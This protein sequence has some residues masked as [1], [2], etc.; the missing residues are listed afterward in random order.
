MSVA[1]YLGGWLS[2]R[3]RVL[4]PT[5]LARYGDYIRKDL[6]PALGTLRL[7]DLCHQHIERFP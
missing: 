6:S 1:Q 7:E 4:K 3:T 5:S 2:G